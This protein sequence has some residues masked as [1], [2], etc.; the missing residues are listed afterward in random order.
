ME[1]NLVSK[2]CNFAY[3]SA[4]IGICTLGVCPAFAAVTLAVSAVMKNKKVEFDDKFAKKNKNS[5]YFEHNLAVFCLL[6]ML[7]L[8]FYSCHSF[9]GRSII[10]SSVMSIIP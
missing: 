8:P 6:L 5:G 10:P 7:F 2:I 9:S 3:A 1:N 4:I